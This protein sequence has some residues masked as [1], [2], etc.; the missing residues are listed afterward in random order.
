MAL[1]FLPYEIEAVS[2]SSL[3]FKGV[4]GRHQYANEAF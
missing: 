1:K 3:L 4:V 2:P